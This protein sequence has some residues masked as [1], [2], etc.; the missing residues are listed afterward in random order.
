MAIMVFGS[1]VIFSIDVAL[2]Q[3][4]MIVLFQKMTPENVESTMMAFSASVI[5]LSR[6]VIGSLTGA[7]INKYLVGVTED[8]LSKLYILALIDLCSC[9]YELLIIPMIPTKKDIEEEMDKRKENEE[10]N[11]TVNIQW[12][13]HYHVLIICNDITI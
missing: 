11:Q 13:S 6:G 8:D 9:F 7:A 4:P 3:L 2:T 5:N 12:D 10:N 1:S